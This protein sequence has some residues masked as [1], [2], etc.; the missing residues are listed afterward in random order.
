MTP[1][2]QHDASNGYPSN[3]IPVNPQA[4][5][6]SRTLRV[7]C[8]GAGMSGLTLAHEM[9]VSPDLQEL[10]D[11]VIYE[12]NIDVGG[13]W[14]ENRYLGV[15]D[16]CDMLINGAG[17]LNK[18]KWPAIEGLSDFTGELVHTAHRSDSYS[19]SRSFGILRSYL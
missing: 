11:F 9:K 1:Q 16:Q 4:T 10:I 19:L 15:A 6:T 5:F 2:Q 13:T 17:F 14:F 8:I 3:S 7:M 12:K 18:W